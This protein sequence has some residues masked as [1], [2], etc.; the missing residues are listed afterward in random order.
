MAVPTNLDNILTPDRLIFYR[1]VNTCYSG[2]IFA[3]GRVVWL[4]RRGHLGLVMIILALFMCAYSVLT[5]M[6]DIL[7]LSLTGLAN[8]AFL[9]CVTYILAGEET[10]TESLWQEYSRYSRNLTYIVMNSRHNG[11][12]RPNLSCTHTACTRRDRL[13]VLYST[14]CTAHISVLSQRSYDA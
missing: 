14:Y 11:L 3:G 9:T 7:W 8:L 1:L 13:H 5:G 10:K 6:S 2:H 4:G 12:S